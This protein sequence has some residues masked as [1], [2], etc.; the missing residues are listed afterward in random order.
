MSLRH[1]NESLITASLAWLSE[2]HSDAAHDLDHV[3]RVV[4]TADK[5]GRAE[6]AQLDV[7][8]PAA[9]LH[10][11]VSIDKRDPRRSQASTLSAD[12]AIE[13][14]S[15]QGYPQP[16]LAPIHHAIASHSWSA[17]LETTTLE[18][19]VLQDA[20]RLDALGAIGTARCLMLGGQWQSELYH[21]QDPFAQQ[22][23]YDDNRYS[24]DHF[25][26]KL[27]HLPGQL[28]TVAGR[29]EGERRWRWMES[30]IEQLKS[31]LPE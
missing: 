21:G 13:W 14:L 12:A 16:L 11:C 2:N 6:G 24:L 20:D 4:A 25:F 31:E 10:D 19:R 29:Q 3:L 15:Q 22:R 18:A 30:F 17:G 7:L 1:F 5:L 8:L 9:Y 23:E 28:K 27:Q 26:V